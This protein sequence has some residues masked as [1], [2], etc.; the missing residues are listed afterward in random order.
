MG[1]MAILE[2][3]VAV[4]TGGGQGVGAGIA[5]AL[6]AE[7]AVVA[8]LGRTLAKLEAT[9]AEIHHRGGE[10]QAFVCD[11]T[12]AEDIDAAIMEV[13]DEFGS[14]DILVNNAQ[15]VPLGRLL[16][17]NDDEYQEG[18]DSG[19]L[20][21]FRFMKACYPF[22]RGDGSIVNLASSAAM[23]SD[24]AGFGAY[25]AAKEAI[26]ALSRAAACEWGEDN[27]RVN[28]IMPLAMSP[29]MSR[30]VEGG[31]DDVED[32]LSTVPLGRVGDCEEDVGRVVVFLCG[33]DASYITGHTLPIDG[34]Q[35]FLR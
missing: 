29:A 35:A 1:D 33:P 24:S 8:V 19:P 15:I 17:I 10:A 20:A 4:V 23:R 34:G 5:L 2:N 11:V 22:L 13:V 25:A 9:C 28:C 21:T 31:G 18:M 14:I 32:F 7:G 16:E 3:K 12:E 27:V 26:R 30:W 6:A